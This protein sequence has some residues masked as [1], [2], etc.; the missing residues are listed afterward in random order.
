MKLGARRWIQG[1][2]NDTIE[3][4]V[5][6]NEISTKSLWVLKKKIIKGMNEEDQGS[7]GTMLFVIDRLGRCYPHHCEKRNVKL[8]G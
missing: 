7:C 4:A 3:E 5:K 8:E 2:A 1:N 6:V